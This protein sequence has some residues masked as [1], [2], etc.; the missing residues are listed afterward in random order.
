MKTFL[1]NILTEIVVKH[2]GNMWILFICILADDVSC[3]MKHV[4]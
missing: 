3:F 4:Q 1:W 2:Y